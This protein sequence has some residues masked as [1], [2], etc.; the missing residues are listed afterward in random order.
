MSLSKRYAISLVA[1]VAL[2]ALGLASPFNSARGQA[3]EV[4]KR[5]VGTWRLVS[6]V[7][8]KGEKDPLRGANPRGLIMYDA[9]GNMAAQIMPDRER[10]KFEVNKA[11]PEEAQA[12]LL[13]YIAYFGTYSVDPVAKTV[14]H[15]REGN[16]NP[17]AM[18]DF[19]R[20]YEFVGDDKLILRPLENDNQ[21]TW[22]RVK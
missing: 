8:A 6:M 14:I 5:F 2:V 15:H 1:L 9:Y 4:A 16:I 3:S 22:E 11:T 19:V 10:P 12:A 13:G 17:G 21:L 20:R 7:N 18:G